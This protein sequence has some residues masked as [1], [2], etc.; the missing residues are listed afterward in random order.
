MRIDEIVKNNLE[1]QKK[2]PLN[3]EEGRQ[4]AMLSVMT[5]ISETLAILTDIYGAVHGRV[6]VKKD[7]QD[8]Q[9]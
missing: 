8:A 9:Q 7:D 6:I 2:C 5:D 3:T 1:M 4:M